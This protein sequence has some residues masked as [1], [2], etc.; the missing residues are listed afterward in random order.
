M[1]HVAFLCSMQSAASGRSH[2]G[3]LLLCCM[4]CRLPQ[5]VVP[6]SAARWRRCMR[7]TCLS[8]L[9]SSD[10]SRAPI[11]LPLPTTGASGANTC[12][13]PA[14]A[15]PIS[16][17]VP[18]LLA[19]YH[20]GS[21]ARPGK[22]KAQCA[23]RAAGSGRAS[24]DQRS[25][26]PAGPTR[27][28]YSQ[29]KRERACLAA[30]RSRITSVV[31][32]VNGGE[33]CSVQQANMHADRSRAASASVS[34]ATVPMGY[35]AH[36]PPA[37]GLLGTPLRQRCA[38]KALRR[39]RRRTALVPDP[40]ACGTPRQPAALCR[41]PTVPCS[42]RSVRLQYPTTTSLAHMDGPADRAGVYGEWAHPGTHLHRD[43]C[44]PRHTSAHADR[45]AGGLCAA[46]DDTR[47]RHRHSVL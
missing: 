30:L 17:S 21:Y 16:P 14:P 47:A 20:K 5:K 45:R 46:H 18:P 40:C 28:A 41:T 22:G 42:T 10:A 24:A 2:D 29:S 23:G 26:R 11:A 33:R 25:A 13:V 8:A 15:T 19:Q 36:Q 35:R 38:H 7:Q 34:T 3:R 31:A 27:R 6:L 9:V 4:L 1:V 37:H 44:S 43:R 32:C 12:S 39:R